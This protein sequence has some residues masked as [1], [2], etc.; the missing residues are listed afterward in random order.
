MFVH[1]YIGTK[2]VCLNGVQYNLWKWV[3]RTK[4]RSVNPGSKY[5][6]PLNHLASPKINF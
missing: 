4:I 6:Y 1:E 3:L 2:H 5:L